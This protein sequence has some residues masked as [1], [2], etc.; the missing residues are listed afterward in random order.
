LERIESE[1]QRRTQYDTAIT[2]AREF[3]AKGELDDASSKAQLALDVWPEK[4]DARQLLDRIETERLRR[5][6]Y[7]TALLAAKQELEKDD[8]DA[9]TRQVRLALGVWPEGTEAKQLLDGIEAE[10]QRRVQYD[11]AITAA[12]KELERDNLEAAV[13]K[14]QSAL[15]L[16]PEKAE[17]KQLLDRLETDRKRKIKY[18][19]AMAAARET[20]ERGDLDA[21]IQKVQLAL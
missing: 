4:A 6:Q 17:A 2:A 10:R 18:D 1:R 13:Q 11:A 16:W 12:K 5:I 3:L 20:L 9:A 15:G 8:F 7:D 14:A 21:A 19:A